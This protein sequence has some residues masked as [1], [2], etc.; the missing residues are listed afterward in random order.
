[1]SQGFKYLFSAFEMSKRGNT[2]EL[3]ELAGE[4]CVLGV[5][6]DITERKLVAAELEAGGL[7]GVEATVR[8]FL[9]GE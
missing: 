4:P 8:K 3:I 6:T 2:A 7:G 1:M 9:S 5:L